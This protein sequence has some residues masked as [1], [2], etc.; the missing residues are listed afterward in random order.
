MTHEKF[1][2]EFQAQLEFFAQNEQSNS[3]VCNDKIVLV[4]KFLYTDHKK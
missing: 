4:L 1:E 2:L 3:K